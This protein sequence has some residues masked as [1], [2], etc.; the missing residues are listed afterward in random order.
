MR[1]Y[2]TIQDNRRFMELEKELR[3]QREE[4]ENLKA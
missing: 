1:D 3:K 2:D 4:I